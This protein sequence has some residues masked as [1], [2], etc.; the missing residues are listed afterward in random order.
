MLLRKAQGCD[1]A[2]ALQRPVYGLV[3]ESRNDAVE[4]PLGC[5]LSINDAN[6]FDA[7]CSRRMPNGPEDNP[8]PA[9]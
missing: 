4:A 7:D 5:A 3:Y 1:N 6:S 2:S 8:I 9:P